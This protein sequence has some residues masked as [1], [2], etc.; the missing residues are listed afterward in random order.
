MEIEYS[1]KYFRYSVYAIGISLIIRIIIAILLNFG[2]D[3]VYYWLYAKYPALSYF[4]HPAGMAVFLQMVT[5]NLSFESELAIRLTSIIPSTINGFI[6]FYLL[7]WL[8]SSRTGFY[9][10]ILYYSSFYFMLIC[11]IFIIPDGL[12][13][14]FWLL[15]LFYFLK[16]EETQKHF[17]LFL[18]AI[19][20]ALAIFT[21]YHAIFL[22]FGM[23]LYL[24]IYRPKLFRNIKLYIWLFISL[25]G[26]LP[27]LIWNSRNNWQSFFFH[28]GRVGVS[29]NLLLFS[30][31]KELGGQIVYTNIIIFALIV[32]ALINRSKIKLGKNQKGI[33]F[34]FSFP[35]II[36]FLFSSVFKPTLLHWSA[37]GY[38]PLLILA[39]IYLTNLSHKEIKNWI[40]SAQLLLI[41]T[42]VLGIGQIN[43]GII[44]NFNNETPTKLGSEDPTLD[45][46]GWKEANENFSNLLN[47][48]RVNT[49]KIVA[50]KWFNAA[51][52]DYYIC[53]PNNLT[54]IALGPLNDIHEYNRINKIRGGLQLGEDVWFFAFSREF[55]NPYDEYKNNFANVKL[56]QIYPIKRNGK[57]VE[58]FFVYLLENYK[59]NYAY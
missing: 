39:A 44:Y 57:T 17:H 27:I 31:L 15:V 49:R 38:L 45:I 52:I 20:S 40:L 5:L 41:V 21:K 51:H 18:A 59:G 56:I 54:L 34:C 43:Y 6:I 53:K 50:K 16:W 11:G 55:V 8:S 7:K 46:F 42:I 29:E 48:T 14:T 30:F 28:S 12:L 37:I 22:V 33:L 2:N 25:T 26:T 9:G 19:F 36:T 32:F 13:S 1:K 3:E 23:G 35:L 10:V 24:I 4:D 47:E 58:Y